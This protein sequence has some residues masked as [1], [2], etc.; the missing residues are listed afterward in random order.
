MRRERNNVDFPLWRKKVDKTL[1]TEGTPLPNWAADMWSLPQSF[2]R[3]LRKKDPKSQVVINFDGSTFDGNIYAKKKLKTKT[4]TKT[5]K[6]QYWLALDAEL[7]RLLK[8]TFVMSYL[9]SIEFDLGGKD[10]DVNSPFWEFIDIEY[11]SEAHAFHFV[12]HYIQESY[13]PNLFK[14]F[15]ESYVNERIDVQN[16]SDGY[17]SKISKNNWKNKKDLRNNIDS[18]NSLYTLLDT[19]N[20]ELY[21][22]ETESLHSRFSAERKEIPGWDKYRVDVLPPELAPY[23][24]EIERLMIRAMAALLTNEK[25]I[26]SMGISDYVLKN[27]K[28]D[29]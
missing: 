3:D 1:F 21:V 23:R 16:R 2:S 24:K 11:D 29:N 26:P 14:G 4:N 27:K 12:A 5:S 8:H 6:V 13:F 10:S 15:I 19:K 7:R 22:G 20:R 18:T 28:I 25:G 17:K 9:R